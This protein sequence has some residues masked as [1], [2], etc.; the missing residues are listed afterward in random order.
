MTSSMSHWNGGPAGNR[1]TQCHCHTVGRPTR[2]ARPCQ[3]ALLDFLVDRGARAVRRSQ[4]N[5]GRYNTGDHRAAYPPHSEVVLCSQSWLLL[6]LLVGVCRSWLLP[7]ALEAMNESFE[8]AWERWLSESENDLPSRPDYAAGWRDALA[9]LPALASC[10]CL[11][12][13]EVKAQYELSTEHA[14][15][16]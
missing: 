3:A 10:E 11:T 6:R 16:R 4:D 13:R 1:V 5:S 7:S 15:E 2:R 14:G 9:M 12:C 8:R